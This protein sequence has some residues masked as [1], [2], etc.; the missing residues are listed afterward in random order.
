M[1]SGGNHLEDPSLKYHTFSNNTVECIQKNFNGK[2]KGLAPGGEIA[3]FH[4]PLP[5]C[6]GLSPVV[7]Q[8]SL[9]D[10]ALKSGAVPAP[11]GFEPFTSLVLA[12]EINASNH[13]T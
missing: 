10:A 7:G 11:F 1:D 6:Q 8:N 4:I 3:F 5:Q 2:S 12:S 9:F 13:S